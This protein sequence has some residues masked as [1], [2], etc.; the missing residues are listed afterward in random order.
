MNYRLICLSV[1]MASSC[2]S[3][4]AAKVVERTVTDLN[5]T[6]TNPHKTGDTENKTDEYDKPIMTD[7]EIGVVM[8][9]QTQELNALLQNTMTSVMSKHKNWD[10]ELQTI[11][12]DES[13]SKPLVDVIGVD[14]DVEAEYMK[15]RLTQAKE[16]L[17]T[18]RNV[19]STEEQR[20]RLVKSVFPVITSM[21][22]TRLPSRQ[23]TLNPK[24]AEK[25]IV[26]MVVIGA[27]RYSMDWFK[28]NVEE[29]R[30]LHA[31]VVVTQVDN[32]TDF[33]AI[34]NFAPDLEFIPVDAS[35]FLKEINVGVYPIIITQQGAF[36]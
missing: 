10:F 34:H 15:R 2:S 35:L 22:P 17:K 23:I 25:V 12:S 16:D 9:T 11:A 26:P 29:I 4:M 33:Q 14:A 5:V 7:K 21:K 27:D 6:Y 13:N 3:V 19:P 32:I 28:T 24:V 1:L 31:Q 30:R 36:Q 20:E 18:G 8:N